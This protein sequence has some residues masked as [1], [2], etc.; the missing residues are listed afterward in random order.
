M[1][2]RLFGT[3]TYYRG[4]SPTEIALPEDGFLFL[5]LSLDR[6]LSV[7]VGGSGNIRSS[8]R[9]HVGNRLRSALDG[10]KLC[11]DILLGTCWIKS[12]SALKG[13]EI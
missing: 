4:I 1:S 7:G 6:G 10:G 13:S 9:N 11:E 3:V 8:G 2:A 12:R 5:L